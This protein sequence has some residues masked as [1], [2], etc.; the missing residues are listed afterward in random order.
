MPRL[1]LTQSMAERLRPTAKPVTYFDLNLPGFGVRVSPKGRKT[2]IAMYTVNGKLVMET[3]GTMQVIP[4]VADARERARKSI[5]QARD[6]IHPKLARIEWREQLYAKKAW[7]AASA[8][9]FANLTARYLDEYAY[10]NT[11][12][13]TA[14]ETERLLN[15]ASRH[16]AERAVRDITKADVSG[17]LAALSGAAKANG[18]TAGLI[19]ANHLLSVVRRCLRWAV[20]Q[21]II[22]A[23]P[24]AGVP[25]PLARVKARERVLTDD[26]MVRLWHGCDQLDPH[27]AA[28]FRLLLLTAQRK[29][30][31]SGM[32]RGELDLAGRVWHLPG[33]R[34]KNGRAH[35][36][37][38]CD[39]A[40][41]IINSANQRPGI[42]G[43]RLFPNGGIDYQ[44]RKLVAIADVS[45]VRIHDLRRSAT[46]GMARLGVAPH[47]TDRILNHK[48]GAIS[49][50]A[51]IYNRFLYTEQRRSAL[52]LW[53]GF[54]R[55]LLADPPARP[56]L[57][58]PT[59]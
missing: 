2:W 42:S 17:L 59:R 35:D 25:M 50:T 9:T 16:F 24:S 58:R 45:D 55:E 54:V 44:K 12:A 29:S 10:R 15:R 3:I 56:R 41:A 34:T 26:E 57:R 19:E 4:K 21:D 52:D 14:A 38:L 30:E 23:D 32:R 22:T 5:L 18:A 49:G 36:V 53:G 8:F 20:T 1:N 6:G 31:V 27:F 47:V 37:H 48:S 33:S 51:A 39:M 7:V 13:S 28:I 11:R 46:T 40:L 43:D